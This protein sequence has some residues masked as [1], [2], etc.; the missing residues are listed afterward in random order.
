MKKILLTIVLLLGSIV[1]TQPVF[2]Y[3]L[4]AWLLWM[5]GSYTSKHYVKNKVNLT[6][7]T[8]PEVMR[9]QNSTL[10][11]QIDNNA[12][13]PISEGI[14]QLLFINK[15]SNERKQMAIP[16]S[17]GAKTSDKLMLNLAFDD[18]GEV[19]IISEKIQFKGLF[20]AEKNIV[21]ERSMIVLPMIYEVEFPNTTMAKLHELNDSQQMINSTELSDENLGIR[22]Y[23][24]GDNMRQIHWKLSAKNEELVVVIPQKFVDRSFIVCLEVEDT[25]LEEKTILTEVYLSVIQ[26]LVKENQQ[27]MT[28]MNNREILVTTNNLQHI[29][30]ELLK[31]TTMG[32]TEAQDKQL[33]VITANPNTQQQY[34]RAMVI[35]LEHTKTTPW[36]ITPLNFVDELKQ[37][38]RK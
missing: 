19:E 15:R 20:S 2:V 37:L 3:L 18:F 35:V 26:Q 32:I 13:L 23:T 25:S 38:G 31:E 21:N 29:Q 14:I 11:I 8:E 4:I 7:F 30:H 6:L 16:F 17:I 36:S 28:W 10:Q 9:K 33:I 22:P 24:I 12:W 27:V 5:I 1:S 34:K